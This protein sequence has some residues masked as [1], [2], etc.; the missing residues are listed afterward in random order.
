MKNKNTDVLVNLKPRLF[1]TNS[2]INLSKTSVLQ[3]KDANGNISAGS[4]ASFRYD[5]VGSGI[6]STQQFNVDWSDFA[7]HTFYNSAQ[8][9]TNEAFKTI[10]NN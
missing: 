2:T 1:K 6:K 9:K 5:P 4:T 10:I 7:Q 3:Q 8:V